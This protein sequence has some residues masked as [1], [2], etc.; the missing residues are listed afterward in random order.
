MKLLYKVIVI[1]LVVGGLSARVHA[2]EPTP[3][4]LKEVGIEEHL[5]QKLPL[6]LEFKDEQGNS[7]A[8]SK[9]FDGQH[10]VI[11]ALVYYSC[12][13][14]CNFLLN[15]LTATFKKMTWN[16]GDQFQLVAVS[17]DPNEK[18]D[19]AVKKMHAYVESYGRPQTEK[20]W[21]FLTGAEEQIKK[22]AGEVG[23]KY[24]Y[25]TDQKQYAH[26]AAIYV[27]TPDGKLS[28]YLYG[29]DF[30]PRDLR[31]ALLEATQGKIG[32]IVDQFLLFCYHYDPKGRKYALMATNLMKGAGAMTVVGIAGFLAV[33]GKGKKKPC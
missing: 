5:G 4:E 13:N 15:G 24:K 7:V 16:V 27:L 9:Y 20:G 22:L 18:P 14:L 19:L 25:D 32:S 29:I 31:L 28:R 8:L 11:L 26:A 6:D 21:H 23:F 2:A 17:I 33:L 3:I 10:P 30:N 1:F 12:P